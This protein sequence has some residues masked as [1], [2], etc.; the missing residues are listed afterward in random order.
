[1]DRQIRKLGIALL[2]LF[3]IAFA[4]VNYIQV[5][6]ADRIAEDPA[7]RRGGLIAQYKVDRGSILA[8]DGTTVLAS[9]RKSPGALR[10][11]RRYPHAELYAHAPGFY[12]SVSGRTEL[13]QSY[14]ASL[15]GDPAELL[16]QTLTDLILGRPKQGAT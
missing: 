7:R 11:Q 4:Q 13:E 6:A 9:S 1:M 15:T 10:F 5:F 2:A 14:T 3:L 8:A 16:P 12:S